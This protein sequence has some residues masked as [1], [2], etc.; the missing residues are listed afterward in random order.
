MDGAFIEGQDLRI[1]DAQKDGRMGRYDK[2]CACAG[3]AVDL[4]QKCQLPLWGKRRLRLVEQVEA[5]GT[6]C[7]LDQLQETLPM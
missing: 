7:V 3:A 2:L 6:E 4:H 5:V 1:R